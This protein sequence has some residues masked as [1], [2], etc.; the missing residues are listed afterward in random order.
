MIE[1]E[2]IEGI[3]TEYCSDRDIVLVDVKINKANN[4][5]V[6]FD[7]PGRNANIEDCVNLSR[8][9]ESKLDRDKEDFSLTVS[10]SGKEI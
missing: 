9:I 3:A 10:S 7:T 6:Y 8:Y 2:I 5:K 4:I 1:K